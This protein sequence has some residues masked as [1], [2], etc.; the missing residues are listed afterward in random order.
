MA[1][2][3]TCYDP[4][5]PVDIYDLGLIYELEIHANGDVDVAM[6]LTAPGCPVAGTLPGDVAEAVAGVEGVG[7]VAVRLTWDPPWD[8]SRMTE[9]ARFELNMW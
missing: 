7:Q 1:A 3:K 8:P 5:I 9:A 2:L 6:T 4:Q